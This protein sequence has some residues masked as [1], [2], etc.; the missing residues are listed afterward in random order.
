MTATQTKVQP[1]GKRVLIKRSEA[2]KTKG[3]IILPDSAQEKPRQGEVISV[4]P[5]AL[6]KNG[7]TL[8]MSVKVG[9]TVLYSSYSG[10]Q[11]EAGSSDEEFLIL[12]EDDILGIIE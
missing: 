4:G 2:V 11:V 8:P 6:D 9:Q 5:G 10:T 12:S 3:G 7:N 1:L